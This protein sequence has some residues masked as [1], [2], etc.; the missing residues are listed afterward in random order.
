MMRTM[1]AC[2]C[3]ALLAACEPRS[4]L[5]ASQPLV[6][7]TRADCVATDRMRARFD[8]ALTALGREKD[9][10]FLEALGRPKDY[11]ILDADTLSE[12]DPRRGYGTPTILYKNVDLFGMPEPPATKNAPT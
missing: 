6:F 4:E 7:L 9:Y 8:E 3:V 11:A 1:F 10:A 5:S 2:G 12:N